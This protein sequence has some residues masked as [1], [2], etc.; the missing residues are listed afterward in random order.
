MPQTGF[1]EGGEASCGSLAVLP[2]D[3]E[4]GNRILPWHAQIEA[5]DLVI[6]RG[7]AAR[8][9]H[10]GGSRFAW[11]AWQP[12]DVPRTILRKTIKQVAGTDTE[13]E[14]LVRRGLTPTKIP[15]G[16]AKAYKPG[17]DGK[18]FRETMNIPKEGFLLTAVGA[19]SA[20]FQRLLEVFAIFQG[21]H[22]DA[23]LYIHTDPS[24][25]VD[26]AEYAAKLGIPPMSL[27][28]PSPYTHHRGA[29]AEQ[30]ATMYVAADVHCV[31]N[32]AICPILEAQ[33]CGTPV[34]TTERAEIA[35]AMPVEGLGAKVPPITHV[36]QEPLLDV[37]GWV[38]ELAFAYEMSPEARSNHSQV[39]HAAVKNFGWDMIYSR[40]WRPLITTLHAEE[41]ERKT[42]K[43]LRGTEPEPGKRE[44]KFL[45]DRGYVK[46]YGCEVVRKHEAGG[47]E[48]DEREQNALIIA[49][50]PHPNII[51]ILA[52]GTDGYGRY[53]FDIPK[54]IPLNERKGDFTKEEGDKILDGIRSALAHLHAQGIAHRDLGPKNVLLEQDGTPRL[55]DFDWILGGLEPEVAAMCDYDPLNAVVINFAVPVMRSRIS[56]RGF[57][58][59]VT[60]VRNLPNS[61]ATSNPD[62]PYQMLDGVGERD[63]DERW[64]DLEPEVEGKRVLDLGC[65][66]GYFTARALAEG[67]MEVL[68]VDRDVGIIAGA[69]VLHPELDGSLQVLNLNEKMPEGEFDVCFCLS[70]WQHLKEGR[71]HLLKY[72]KNIPLVYW[73]DANLTKPEL[74]QIGFEV[75]RI[76][77]SERGRN[78]FKLESGRAK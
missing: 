72:L 38:R 73:E 35:E 58:R 67:A 11:L 36:D 3:D 75:E 19:A 49:A 65:N 42:W 69:R 30:L 53:W 32:R 22:E 41:Q 29:T 46:E 77:A 21:Q 44:S 1:S 66:L 71:P 48:Q 70:V 56:T 18:A 5:I 63:S 50:G 52:E 76:G 27:R 68:G 23:Y 6:S 78:L 33:A 28:F 12:G 55:F 13:C 9:D 31:P 26:I 59:I 2:G 54:L 8:L 57:H 25:P 24:R 40:Y 51:P 37:D 20:H 47:S 39:C 10:Y 60:H 74:E 43:R 14:E 17:A 45:E 15:R 34:L 7:S 61:E 4:L 16:I 62:V 64:A